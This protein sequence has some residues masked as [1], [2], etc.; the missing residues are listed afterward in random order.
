MS[1]DNISGNGRIHVSGLPL[2]ITEDDLLSLFD[3]F[4]SIKRIDLKYGYAYL[5]YESGE[6][7][8]AAVDE[9]KGYEFKGKN[10]KVETAF[11]DRVPPAKAPPVI[12]QELRLRVLDIDSECI[13]KDLKDWARIAGPVHYAATHTL[14]GVPLGIIEY[15]KEEDVERA[16]DTL[17]KEPLKGRKV[18]VIKDDPNDG[19][20][21]PP[22]NNP[23]FG[24][25][26]RYDNRGG[27]FD[28]PRD[29]DRNTQFRRGDNDYDNRRRDSYDDRS[30]D[31]GRNQYND[32]YD[33]KRRDSY[34][35]KRRDSFDNRGRDYDNRD[36][37]SY[38]NRG[39]DNY[40]N[41]GRENYDNRGRENYDRPRD[42]GFDNN[43]GRDNNYGRGRDDGPHRNDYNR[44]NFDRPRS[45]S[46]D[47][48]LDNRRGAY[49]R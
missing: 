14:H 23:K 10:I 9:M 25:G 37:D 44:P 31:F 17:P 32:S 4:G 43:R 1:N 47:R 26:R 5:F 22:V 8:N 49:G 35:N 13:W 39:R 36:R 45:R 24:G 16:L 28:R 15:E 27:R 3:K 33:N 7:A 21:D 20:F 48:N 42:F 6:H 34:D 12:R 11:T 19:P 18:K 46:R 41:R 2:D 29:F 40:D 30:R 38:D